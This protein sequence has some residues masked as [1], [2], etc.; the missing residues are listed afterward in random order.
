MIEGEHIEDARLRFVAAMLEADAQRTAALA[1][2][3]AR[4]SREL[5]DAETLHADALAI[6]SRDLAL[7][8]AELRP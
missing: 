7:A 6:A 2:A 3:R 5:E 4:Y 8:L 1:R